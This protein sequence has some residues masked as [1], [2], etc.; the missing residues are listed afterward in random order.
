MENS[1]NT[2]EME[3]S[4]NNKINSESDIYREISQFP[5]K[6]KQFIASIIAAAG[7]HDPIL[8]RRLLLSLH[9]ADI[10]SIL[11]ELPEESVRTIIKFLGE[12]LDSE[13][14]AE[15]DEDTRELVV[16]ILPRATI[17]RAI[18]DL[19]SDDAVA[20]VEDLDE[21]DRAEVLAQTS[22]VVRASIEGAL[23]FEEETAGRLMQREFVAAP[24]FWDVGR[25]IDHMRAVGEDLPDLFFEVYVVDPYF[26]PI[27][28][29]AVSRIMRAPRK[30]TLKE[31]MD[32]LH[33]IVEPETDQEEVALSFQKYHLISAPVVDEAGRLT[34]MI[35]VDDIVQ[36]LQEENEEDML[37]LAG[38]S[39][40]S[41]TDDVF[42]SV[43]SRLPWLLV[44]LFIAL[45]NSTVIDRF[46]GL[47]SEVVALAVL[48]P[49]GS[50]LGGNA[51]TQTLAVAVRAL[52]QR[53]LTSANSMR[54]VWRE[55]FTGTL[56]GIVIGLVFASVAGLWF[57]SWFIALAAGGVII[58]DF[59][60]AGLAGIL[61]P[62]GLKKLDYD[63]AVASSIFVTFITDLVGFSAFL[64]IAFF[65]IH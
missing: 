17:A 52:A 54:I 20:F 34:G 6:Q 1:T 53:E 57:H 36:V 10:A 48:M 16:D 14:F 45:V 40:A 46:S 22:S 9:P 26:K 61:I 42:E 60:V 2:P 32:N 49:V 28:A 29:V 35:T 13:V 43:K 37:A 15:L 8:L 38:V 27:G 55:F 12:E 51:G 65:L 30:T 25:T 63:P 18:E 19:D 41:A 21:D 62:L 3:T 5:E 47:I 33:V 50:A 64:T 58:I 44:N 39:D 31:L 24:E 4:N 56:N 59:I 23:S 11:G 7:D